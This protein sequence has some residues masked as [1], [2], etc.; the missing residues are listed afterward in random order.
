MIKRRRSQLPA[1]LAA[2][3]A[4]VATLLTATALAQFPDRTRNPNTA[5]KLPFNAEDAESACLRLDHR[6]RI[7][8]DD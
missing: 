1:V 6:W 8:A 2:V 5:L 7:K 3:L 4:V